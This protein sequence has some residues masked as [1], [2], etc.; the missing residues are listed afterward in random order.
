MIG[1]INRESNI[2]AARDLVHTEGS[3]PKNGSRGRIQYD[4]VRN[5]NRREQPGG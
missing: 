5:E 4:E 1:G 3:A 2:P